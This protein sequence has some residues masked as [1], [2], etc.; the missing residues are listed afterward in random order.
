M[1]PDLVEED[2]LEEDDLPD[3]MPEEL[4]VVDLPEVDPDEL[5]VVDLPEPAEPG[6]TPDVFV[7][8]VLPVDLLPDLVLK[9]PL[10][11]V[12]FGFTLLPGTCLF[13]KDPVEYVLGW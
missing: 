2:L 8:V 6:T 7:S 12:V 3:V 1:L 13:W 10:D 9:V 4:P 5:P 11:T